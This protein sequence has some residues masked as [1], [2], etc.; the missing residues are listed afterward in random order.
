[1]GSVVIY[2]L[3]KNCFPDLARGYSSDN[4]SVNCSEISAVTLFGICLNFLKIPT[5]AFFTPPYCRSKAASAF[6]KKCLPIFGKGYSSDNNSVTCYEIS[7]VTWTGKCSGL[8][9]FPKK[10]EFTPPYSLSGACKIEINS[11]HGIPRSEKRNKSCSNV[12]ISFNPI[13][14]LK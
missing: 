9:Q 6:C 10:R 13:L 1:M 4:D 7:A 12:S 3:C 8:L 2:A 11:H 14:K 5:F